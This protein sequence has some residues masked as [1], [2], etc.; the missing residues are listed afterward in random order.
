MKKALLIGLVLVVLLSGVIG[1]T[2]N[3]ETEVVETCTTS[4]AQ[5]TT[6]FNGDI[7]V[8]AIYDFDDVFERVTKENTR[9]TADNFSEYLA[10]L[11]YNSL[12]NS[13]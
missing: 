9:T 11:E 10:E 1:F 12:E 3:S 8:D 5:I 13:F 4:I 6:E 7:V 2:R